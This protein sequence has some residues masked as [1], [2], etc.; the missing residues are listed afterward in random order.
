MVLHNR[1]FFTA[2]ALIVSILSSFQC[3]YAQTPSDDHGDTFSTA[4]MVELNRSIS[5]N[6]ERYDDIDYFRFEINSAGKII[7][8]TT[9]DIDILGT[10][11][12]N[13]GNVITL[14]D[15]SSSG[16]NFLTTRVLKPG[17][18]YI[19]VSNLSYEETGNYTIQVNFNDSNESG[20]LQ[21][22]T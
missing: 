9:G 4:T 20:K 16:E 5:G 8:F 14:N 17:T 10:L 21:D 15:N 13:S 12:N 19:A 3:L 2:V 11:Q 7:A 6:L 18:Y 1:I 22:Q